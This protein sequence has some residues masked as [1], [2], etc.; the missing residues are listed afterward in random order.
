M[1]PRRYEP[2]VRPRPLKDRITVDDPE[3]IGSVYEILCDA[4][5]ES[6]DSL[7]FRGPQLEILNRIEDS[8]ERTIYSAKSNMGTHLDHLIL[9]HDDE[10][11]IWRHRDY[12]RHQQELLESDS[13]LEPDVYVR[14][15]LLQELDL[16]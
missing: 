12:D 10:T 2:P 16:E 1:A 7:T 8:D 3:A 6:G 13:E 11:V 9:N 5:I 14:K 15:M 4:T